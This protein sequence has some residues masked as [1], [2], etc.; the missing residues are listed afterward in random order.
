MGR[1]LKN[2]LDGARQVLVLWPENDYIRPKRGD[3]LIDHNNVRADCGRITEGLRRNV[4]NQRHG[5]TYNRE[6]A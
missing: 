1:H 6:Y 2:I 5:E 4:K 3:F